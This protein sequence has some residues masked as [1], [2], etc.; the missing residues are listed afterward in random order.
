MLDA[1]VKN[2][3]SM[4]LD[5]KLPTTVPECGIMLYFICFKKLYEQKLVMFADMPYCNS[6][7]KFSILMEIQVFRTF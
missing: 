2:P 6:R 3:G 7:C 4:S 5:R 1:A